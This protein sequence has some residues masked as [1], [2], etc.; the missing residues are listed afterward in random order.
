MA[1]AAQEDPKVAQYLAGKGNLFAVTAD[2]NAK[3]VRLWQVAVKDGK[4]SAVKELGTIPL[5]PA[6][7]DLLRRSL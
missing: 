6:W 5:N 2:L 3:V 1:K 7:E 4:Q